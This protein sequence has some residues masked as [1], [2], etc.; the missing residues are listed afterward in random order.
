MTVASDLKDNLDKVFKESYSLEKFFKSVSASGDREID[1]WDSSSTEMVKTPSGAKLI[2]VPR[3]KVKTERNWLRGKIKE[4]CEENQEVI[5][6]NIRE[7]LKLEGIYEWKF[8][9]DVIAGTGLKSFI[10]TGTVEGKSRPTITLH[11]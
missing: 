1:T 11:V 10:I 6:N 5:I 7:V 2:L 9:E 3:I 8:F 4:F